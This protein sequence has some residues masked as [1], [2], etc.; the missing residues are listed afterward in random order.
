M[1][2]RFRY[3]DFHRRCVGDEARHCQDMP[4]GTRL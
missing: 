3:E 4:V 1:I 2:D